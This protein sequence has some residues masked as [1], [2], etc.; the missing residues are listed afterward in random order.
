MSSDA[1]ENPTSVGIRVSMDDP[2]VSNSPDATGQSLGFVTGLSGKRNILRTRS[3]SKRAPLGWFKRS[4]RLDKI[5]TQ[6]RP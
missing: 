2:S 6:I 5:G 1:F 4:P 3:C